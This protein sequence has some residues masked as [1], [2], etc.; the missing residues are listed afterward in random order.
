MGIA[1][2]WGMGGS[3]LE[4][5]SRVGRPRRCGW[6]LLA[7]LDCTAGEEGAVEAGEEKSSKFELCLVFELG[8]GDVAVE[9]EISLDHDAG[10]L[11]S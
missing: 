11:S 7:K 4:L 2:G 3:L 5:G 1:G 8:S 9:R 6:I 10:Y